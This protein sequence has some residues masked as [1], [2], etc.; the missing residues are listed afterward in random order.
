MAKLVGA[1]GVRA[2]GECVRMLEVKVL[3]ARVA[4]PREVRPRRV[5]EMNPA[6][7]SRGRDFLVATLRGLLGRRLGGGGRHECRKQNRRPHRLSL[8]IGSG[9]FH[10]IDTLMPA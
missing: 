5:R 6:D 10:T 8:P 3:G 1:T 4:V 9:G 7:G 2:D